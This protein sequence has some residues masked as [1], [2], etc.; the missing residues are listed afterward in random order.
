MTT[1][2]GT[3]FSAR[4]RFAIVWAIGE[5]RDLSFGYRVE[6]LDRLLGGCIFPEDGA[7]MRRRAE[8]VPAAFLGRLVF[9]VSRMP[10]LDPP[11]RRALMAKLVATGAGTSP[12]APPPRGIL[13]AIP[14]R[15]AA[16]LSAAFPAGGSPPPPARSRG[17]FPPGR[18]IPWDGV[19]GSVGDAAREVRALADSLADPGTF[20]GGLPDAGDILSALKDAGDRDFPGDAPRARGSR[21]RGGEK[22]KGSRPRGGD[23]PLGTWWGEDDD[24]TAGQRGGTTFCSWEDF[25]DGWW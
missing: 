18:E 23:D 13:R 10:G 20:P 8:S 22:P 24:P 25:P 14:G 1:R 9:H 7:V 19:L 6:M 11:V 12:P 2:A 3:G 4:E 16:L 17:S 5:M 15:I 21:S